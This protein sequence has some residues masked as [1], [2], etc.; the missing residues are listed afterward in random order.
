MRTMYSLTIDSARRDV[1]LFCI[2]RI[3]IF[4]TVTLLIIIITVFARR[5]SIFFLLRSALFQGATSIVT[6]VLK[7]VVCSV[8]V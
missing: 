8:Y 7:I 1:V 6:F 4:D 2:F 3:W 5:G